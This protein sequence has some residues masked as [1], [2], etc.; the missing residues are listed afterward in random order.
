MKNVQ[1][2]KPNKKNTGHACSFWVNE[3]GT[4]QTS[5]LKQSGWN[6]K[7]RNGTF[8]ANKDNPMAR[9]ISKLSH[10]E[11]ASIISAVRRRTEL[12]AY[13]RS[14][15]QVLKISFKSVFDKENVK[16]H[17]GYSFSI[18]KE[19]SEDSTQ[20]ASFYV[21]F[22]HGEGEMLAIY[23]NKALDES[24]SGVNPFAGKKDYTKKVENQSPKP[25]IKE[26]PQQ[27]TNVTEDFDEGDW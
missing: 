12:S 19:S 21:M 27:E 24:F 6:E 1:Y 17:I 15:K 3:D 26:V 23:L 22:D 25:T 4:I 7:T 2:Y 18:N 9:V 16:K 11:C 8:S 14:P 13:H 20:S 10:A 5:M